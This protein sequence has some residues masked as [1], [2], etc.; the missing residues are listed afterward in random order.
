MAH[1]ARAASARSPRRWLRP[2][3]GGLA[4]WGHAWRPVGLGCPHVYIKQTHPHP[5]WLKRCDP[6]PVPEPRIQRASPSDG[7][8]RNGNALIVPV[9]S[10]RASRGPPAF[11]RGLLLRVG[12]VHLA[13]RVLWLVESDWPPGIAPVLLH[14]LP[15]SRALRRCNCRG[16]WAAQPRPRVVTHA[17]WRRALRA[18]DDGLRDWLHRR[19]GINAGSAPLDALAGQGSVGRRIGHWRWILGSGTGAGSHRL[20]QNGYGC[21]CC[22]LVPSTYLVPST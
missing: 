16:S 11:P 15:C 1:A 7:R 19:G 5:F 6:A 22:C 3:H 4:R 10:C 17:L 20:S 8:R 21:V 14:P 13:T 12:R 2:G 9:P 18:V